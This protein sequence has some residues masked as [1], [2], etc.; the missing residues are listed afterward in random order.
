MYES[1]LN[2]TR[3]FTSTFVTSYSVLVTSCQ[4]QK[5]LH[6]REGKSDNI[7]GVNCSGQPLVNE[8]VN[9]Y[10]VVELVVDSLK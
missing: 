2:E 1:I 6:Q 4:T 10:F 5:M 7:H 8:L 9:Y 3:D